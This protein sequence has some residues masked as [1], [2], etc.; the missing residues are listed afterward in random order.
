MF[1]YLR[2]RAITTIPV[3]VGVS[4]A[5]FLMLHFPGDP[6]MMMLTEHRGASAPTHA[7]SV[8]DDAYQEMKR[9]LGLDQPLPIQFGRFLGGV[10]RATSASRFAAAS[11][12]PR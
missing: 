10:L 1:N 11:R 3:L 4:L 12:S 5:V 2:R 7:S 8:S 6:V 9:Q